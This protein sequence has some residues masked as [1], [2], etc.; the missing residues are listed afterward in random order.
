MVFG[1]YYW[2]CTKG[3]LLVGFRGLYVVLGIKPELALLSLAKEL[4][5]SVGLREY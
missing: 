4:I 5:I 3:Q 2:I 1:D